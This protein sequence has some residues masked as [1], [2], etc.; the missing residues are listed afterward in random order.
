APAPVDV[1]EIS[2]KR[3]DQFSLGLE[4]T[5]GGRREAQT[6]IRENLRSHTLHDLRCMLWFTEHGQIAVRMHV[7]ETG[8][9]HAARGIDNTVSIQAN[10]VADFAY[11]SSDD[12]DICLKSWAPC[13]V[14]DRPVADQDR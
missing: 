5:R 12:C 6:A 4:C 3:T 7:D 10:E 1:T 8:T 13:P 11:C 9:N 2:K 14:N